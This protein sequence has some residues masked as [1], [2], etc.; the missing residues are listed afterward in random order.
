VDRLSK[1]VVVL[2]A[3]AAGCL[4]LPGTTAAS[5]AQSSVFLIGDSLSVGTSWYLPEALPRVRVRVDA[6][7]GRP[8]AHGLAVLRARRASLPTV[9]AISL[10]TN[11]DPS[12]VSSFAAGIREVV[13]LAGRD[14]CVIWA[15][16]SRPP[17]HGVSYDGYN[18]LLRREAARNPLFRLVDWAEMITRS[19]WLLEPDRVHGSGTAYERRARATARAVRSCQ[20][21]LRTLA[22][23]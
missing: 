15:T 5:P 8:L 7:V 16:V 1:L 9:I 4:Q 14:R 10:G 20:M 3:V 12:R 11:D 17:V 22:K 2:V 19:P 23:A 6:V 21:R 13:R 18:R